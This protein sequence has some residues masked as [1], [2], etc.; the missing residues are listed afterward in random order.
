MFYVVQSGAESEANVIVG[1]CFF[2]ILASLGWQA[3]QQIFQVSV[4][5]EVL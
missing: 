1:C 4:E 3:P 2:M 5:N